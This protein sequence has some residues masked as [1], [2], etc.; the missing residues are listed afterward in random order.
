MADP[1]PQGAP[2]EGPRPGGMACEA[3]RKAFPAEFRYCPHCA[4][5]LRALDDSLAAHLGMGLPARFNWKLITAFALLLIGLA[6]FGIWKLSQIPATPLAEPSPRTAVSLA[7]QSFSEDLSKLGYEV[8]FQG[9]DRVIVAIPRERWD[10]LAQ[11]SRFARHALVGD[12]RRALSS[13]QRENGD[14]TDYRI[15][16][17]DSAT[18]TL[19]AEETDFNL[20]VHE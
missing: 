7:E 6:S 4:R 5:T 17:R 12:F 10:E 20:K 1:T 19:L 9:P 18:G 2:A 13:R 15:E 3:C 11:E 8:R 16:V 14:E